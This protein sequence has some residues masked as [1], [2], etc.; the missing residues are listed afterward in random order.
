MTY[1]KSFIAREPVRAASILTASLALLALLIPGF[2]EEALLA[3]LVPIL[4]LGEAAR[5]KVTPVDDGEFYPW[6]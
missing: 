2:P 3:L 6:G 1:L 4:G 5:A